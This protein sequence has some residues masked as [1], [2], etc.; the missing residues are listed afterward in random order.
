[1]FELTCSDFEEFAGAIQGAD[2]RVMRTGRE[3]SGW[4]VRDVE[5][6]QV[7]VQLAREGAANVFEAASWPTT[8]NLLIALEGAPFH[9][10]GEAFG[11][12]SIGLLAP[13][14]A[15]TSLAS[16][17]NTWASIA[18]PVSVFRE[19]CAPA[20]HR[21]IQQ[22]MS[23]RTALVHTMPVHVARLHR[24]VSL[25]VR[26]ARSGVLKGAE[27]TRSAE[28]EIVY[29]TAM[30][31]SDCLPDHEDRHG[32]RPP[33]PRRL[34]VDRALEWITAHQEDALRVTDL[35]QAAGVSERTLR[36]VFVECFGMG[37]LGYIRLR[38]VHQVHRELAAADPARTTVTAVAMKLGIWDLEGLAARYR[39]IFGKSPSSTLRDVPGHSQSVRTD[40][41]HRQRLTIS[42]D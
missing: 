20:D 39:R 9:L 8:V 2:S 37:P 18:L 32:G 19:S 31:L 38:Q 27:P 41:H 11:R 26:Q 30:A 16:G 4:W 22:V 13:G 3:E 21:R 28:S 1:M 35:A 23:G 34:V 5:L 24:L 36:T 40:T 14:R 7:G 15:F 6:C 25:V 33:V 17:A 42:L 12:E 10:N 29:A